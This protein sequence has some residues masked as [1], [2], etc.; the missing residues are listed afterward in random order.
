[1]VSG[2]PMRCGVKLLI[3]AGSVGQP[4]DGNPQLSFGIID[5]EAWKNENIRT[6]YDVKGAADAIIRAGL[7]STLGARLEHGI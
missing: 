6:D 2:T 5:T 7:P 1:M 3:N 4:R